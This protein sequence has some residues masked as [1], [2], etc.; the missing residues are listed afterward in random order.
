MVESANG[1]HHEDAGSMSLAADLVVSE[2][3][4]KPPSFGPGLAFSGP[5]SFTSG[6]SDLVSKGFFDG[7]APSLWNG[8]AAPFAKKGA[9]VGSDGMT[10]SQKW[11]V[12]FGPFEEM[13]FYPSSVCHPDMCLTIKG[14]REVQR[15][16]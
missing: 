11:L 10:Q 8:C 16:G 9:N 4:G 13:V 12:G 7:F 5:H 6:C 2:G 14:K 15:K 1:V 3:V